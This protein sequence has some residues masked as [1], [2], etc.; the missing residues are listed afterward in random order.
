MEA[1]AARASLP[2]RTVGHS[3]KSVSAR[4]RSPTSF[5]GVGLK[6]SFEAS[7]MTGPRASRKPNATNA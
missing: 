4:I 5:H 6:A 1:T 2:P 3:A 7:P